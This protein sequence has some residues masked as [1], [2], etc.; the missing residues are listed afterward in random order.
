[1]KKLVMFVFAALVLS[2]FVGCDK[3]DAKPTDFVGTWTTTETED[4]MTLKETLVL[5]ED[6]FSDMLQLQTTTGAF[7]DFL[8]VKGG[9]SV[10]ANEIS[11][12]IE[13][14]GMAELDYEESTIGA[15]EWYEK[16]SASYDL[17]VDLYGG[18]VTVYT[19][20]LSGNELTLIEGLKSTVYT[21]M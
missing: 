13:E 20:E 10:S 16:G 18:V 3:E 14:A 11:L 15:F 6:S 1:M 2:A 21:K 4:G 5:G 12:S 19:Y 8:G 17:V 7:V 9:L